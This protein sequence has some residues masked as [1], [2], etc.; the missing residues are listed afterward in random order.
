M[1]SLRA[2]SSSISRSCLLLGVRDRATTAASSLA[3]CAATRESRLHFSSSS[4][5]SAA[6]AAAA[7]GSRAAAGASPQ[8]TALAAPAYTISE[9]PKSAA[10]TP[11]ALGR[12]RNVRGHSKKLDSL[13][14]QVRQLSVNEA[15][16][17]MAFSPRSRASDV[18]DALIRASREAAAYHGLPK[19][20]LMV[21]AAWTGKHQSSPRI[22]HHSK[23][24]AGRSHKRT[25]QLSV[26]VREMTDAEAAKKN[27][28]KQLPTPESIARLSPRGY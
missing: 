22:R 28:F 3:A 10:E 24:R 19:S 6:E 15:L 5:I 1:F 16:A 8:S 23:M 14:R 2:L 25:S 20:R 11:R 17:Q 26:R 4:S 27:K 18:R 13:A 21:E 12:V 9:L 7:G